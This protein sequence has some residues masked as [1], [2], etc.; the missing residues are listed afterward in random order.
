MRL[1]SAIE[2]PEEAKKSISD[3]THKIDTKALVKWVARD[4]L[5]ITLKFF[6]EVESSTPLLNIF[7]DIGKTFKP[8]TISLSGLGAFPSK[9]RVRVLWV[10]TDKGGEY[11]S[12]LFKNIEDRC[13]EVGFPKEKMNFTPHIT[14]GRVKKGELTFPDI[15]FSYPPFLA[16]N[17]TLFESVLT[18][19]GP[20]YNIVARFPEES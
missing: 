10:G 12:E 5:H 14:T 18:P 13:S 8:F 3:I 15:D 1:F 7:K 2:I 17:I 6:G 4:N 19:T 9:S 11:L 20:I 16:S